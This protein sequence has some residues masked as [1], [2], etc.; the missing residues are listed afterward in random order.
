MIVYFAGPL[1]SVAEIEFNRRLAGSLAAARAD[2]EIVLPQDRAKSLLSQP[3]GKQLV[4]DDCLAMVRKADVVLA[5]LDGEDVDSGTCI[6]LGYAHAWRKPIVGVRTDFR[7]SEDRGVNLMV[8]H[9]CGRLIHGPVES[10]E[11]LVGQTL[12]ALDAVLAQARHAADTGPPDAPPDP[13]A[14]G[15]PVA[16]R[17]A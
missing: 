5:I 8:S 1:F 4:F 6:E 10:T 2:L 12:A 3:D 15:A 7:G 17:G 11:E 9:V 14:N 16:G 13:V